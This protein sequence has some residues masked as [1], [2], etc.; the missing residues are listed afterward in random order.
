MSE[1]QTYFIKFEKIYNVFDLIKDGLLVLPFAK[2]ISLFSDREII[3]AN[4]TVNSVGSSY[5][6]KHI[7]DAGKMLPESGSC[8]ENELCEHTGSKQAKSYY[9]KANSS[10]GF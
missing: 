3:L 5:K 2:L 4:K 1:L 10:K 6:A 8:S 9:R 7:S